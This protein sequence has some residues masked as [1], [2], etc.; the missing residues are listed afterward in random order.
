MTSLGHFCLSGAGAAGEGAPGTQKRGFREQLRADPRSSVWN[1]QT[2]GKRDTPWEEEGV[3][4]G[5]SRGRY[6]SSH[7]SGRGGEKRGHRERSHGGG[8]HKP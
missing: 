1:R 8:H 6:T 3:P 2:L 7:R 5:A 4:E